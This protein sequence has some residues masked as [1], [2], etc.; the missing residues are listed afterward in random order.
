MKKSKMRIAAVLLAVVMVLVSVPLSFYAAETDPQAEQQKTP[1]FIKDCKT[2]DII[3]FGLYPQSKVDDE[4]LTAALDKETKSWV[5]YNYYSGDGVM[6]GGGMAP[7]DYMQYSD[8]EY[9]SQLYR[10]VKFTKF[11]PQYSFESNDAQEVLTYQDDNGY[12]CGKTYYFKYEPLE[13]RVL[14]PASGLVMCAKVI[15]AQA[16]ND[17]FIYA[18]DE[19][20]EGADICWS[21]DQHTVRA[22]DYT[23]SGVRFWLEN[24]FMTEA[25]SRLELSKSEEPTLEN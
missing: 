19:S 14:D 16:F 13:W 22:D 25:F 8:F 4:S 21:D 9:E 12:E 11:R 10:A 5:S 18:K 17:F 24:S 23:K 15:D 3:E 6:T 7:S 20:G 1:D 2:G